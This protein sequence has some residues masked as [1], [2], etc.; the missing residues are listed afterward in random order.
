SLVCKLGVVLLIVN[1]PLFGG[2]YRYQAVATPLRF[3]DGPELR[4]S[5]GHE[6]ANQQARER[7]LLSES[8]PDASNSLSVMAIMGY[9]FIA[10]MICIVLVVL[11]KYVRSWYFSPEQDLEAANQNSD[12]ENGQNGGDAKVPAPARRKETRATKKS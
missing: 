4:N 7:S 6:E 8:K 2:L 10:A 11:G 1:D 5:G 3:Q 12:N 9:C